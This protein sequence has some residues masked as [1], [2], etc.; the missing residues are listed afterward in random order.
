[1]EDSFNRLTM[2]DPTLDGGATEKTE[3]TSTELRVQN[4][5]VQTMV[6]L[7]Q[8][9]SGAV[10]ANIVTM[11]ASNVTINQEKDQNVQLGRTESGDDTVWLTESISILQNKKISKYSLVYKG[12]QIHGEFGVTPVAVKLIPHNTE[13]EKEAKIL[14]KL[15]RHP[16]VVSMIQSGIYTSGPVKYIFIVMEMCRNETLR[17]FANSCEDLTE[18]IR[19]IFTKQLVDGL[20]HIHEKKI[21]H[22]DLKPSNILVTLDGK[23]LKISDFGVS[24]EMRSGRAST[25]L[26]HARVGTDGWRAPETYNKDIISQ[27][28]DIFSLGLVYFFMWSGGRHPFGSDPDDW[29]KNIKKYINRDLDLLAKMGTSYVIDLIA[30]M[31]AFDDAERP[32]CEKIKQHRMLGGNLRCPPML[33]IVASPVVLGRSSYDISRRPSGVS[34]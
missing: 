24:K 12:Q 34:S 30:W 22:R 4:L 31:L 29:N 6:I 33:R 23:H 15:S 17:E 27:K 25:S 32:T 28:A 14:V 13:N 18:E 9:Y 11:G 3:N 1:M 19:M 5:N 26:T 7:K 21:I 20:A 10:N 8:E 16:N 2:E